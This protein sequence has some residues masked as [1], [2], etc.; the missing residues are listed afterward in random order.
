[1]SSSL[2]HFILL[3][4]REKQEFDQL[5]AQIDKL[6]IQKDELE[7][8]IS[9]HAADGIHYSEVVQLS[10]SLAGLS[11]EIEDKTER[12]LELSDIADS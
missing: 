10:K 6:S 4:C 12:W 1:M 9:Q 3:C 5:E 8:K 2:R 7:A 11:A